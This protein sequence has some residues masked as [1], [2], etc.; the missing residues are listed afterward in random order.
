MRV[1]FCSSLERFFIS[2]DTQQKSAM[3]IRIQQEKK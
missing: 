2:M 3:S 1:F